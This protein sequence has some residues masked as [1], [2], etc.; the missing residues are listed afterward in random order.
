MSEKSQVPKLYY[1]GLFIDVLWDNYQNSV[2]WFEKY[3]G[4]KIKMQEDWKV[5]PRCTDGIMT[6]M[7]Y[8]T[9]LITYLTHTRLP[10]HYADRGTVE[11]N[12]R[13][14]FR[15][16]NLEPIHNLLIE[17]DIRVTP[18]YDGPMTRYF[19]L[20]STPEGIRLTLQE[21]RSLSTKELLPSWTRIGVSQLKD[22][23]KWYESYVGMKMV[24]YHENSNFAI[25]ALGLNH[26]EE[27]SLWVIEQQSDDSDRGRVNGQVQ[28]SCWIKDREDFFNYHHF[29]KDCGIETSEIGGFIERGMVGFHFYDEDGNRFNV[30]SM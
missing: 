17:N 4:W 27:E 2:E 19:D 18:I 22:S 8:G 9:W 26:S 10:H 16:Q 21:D 1:D 24:E 11:S 12:V 5:D 23:I 7:D 20:W 25:M 13:A 3:F 15:I 28:P 6:Q 30:S 29:L 14:C